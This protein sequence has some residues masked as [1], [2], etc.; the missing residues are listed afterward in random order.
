MNFGYYKNTD[1]SILVVFDPAGHQRLLLT[2]NLPLSAPLIR[3]ATP[4]EIAFAHAT[5]QRVWHYNNFDALLGE[6]E[7]AGANRA[8]LDALVQMCLNT[9]CGDN[10]IAV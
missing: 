10:A 2:L 7:R 1:A 5:G 8:H 3:P 6:E 4:D 9:L